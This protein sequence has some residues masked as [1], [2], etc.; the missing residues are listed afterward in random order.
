[1]ATFVSSSK[2]QL[3]IQDLEAPNINDL[4]TKT[5]SWENK[6]T[7]RSTYDIYL[8]STLNYF[9]S[10]K[11]VAALAGFFALYSVAGVYK[12]TSN[13]IKLVQRN[14]NPNAVNTQQKFLTG[15]FDSKMNKK[16]ALQILGLTEGKLNEK[17]LKKTHRS[18]M[19]ANHP[20]KGGSPYLATKINES[21]DWLLKNVSVPKN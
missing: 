16:E 11:G 9:E 14:L 15:G 17:S 12:S 7:S 21:K 19:L 13:F 1:M 3:I 5:T 6:Y 8:N 2:R 4:I 10:H 18:I 20:D